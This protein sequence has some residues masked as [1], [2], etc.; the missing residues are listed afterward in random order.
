MAGG[1]P[2]NTIGRATTL[3]AFCTRPATVCRLRAAGRLACCLL[4]TLATGCGSGKPTEAVVKA[5]SLLPLGKPQEAIDALTDDKSAE[6]HYLKYVAL[7]RLELADAAQAE[8]EKAVQ[9]DPGNEKYK[10][11][12]LTSK[13]QAGDKAAAEEIL[14]LQKEHPS[15]ASVALAAMTAYARTGDLAG[16]MTAFKTSV[17]LCDQVPEMLPQMLGVALRSQMGP[18]AQTVMAKL[19]KLAPDYPTLAAQRI[20]VMLITNRVDEALRLARE[21]YEKDKTS[22]SAALI[23]ARAISATPATPEYDKTMEEIARQYPRNPNL[24]QMHSTYLAKS[25]RLPQAVEFLNKAI[26]QVPPDLRD[27]ITHMSIVLPLEMK[28]A[29]LASAQIDRHRAAIRDPLYLGYYEGRLLQVR[30]DYAG[31][32]AAYK[33]VVEAAKD[34]PQTKAMIAREALVWMRQ[35]QLEQGRSQAIQKAADR[36]SVLELEEDTPS[37]AETPADQPAGK[38]APA[39]ASDN[40]AGSSSKT[41]SG[42]TAKAAEKDASTSGGKQPASASKA[43]ADSTKPPAAPRGKFGAGKQT[44]GPVPDATPE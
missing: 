40:G 8:L 32:M 35:I 34:D 36:M 42:K 30:K 12:Q 24:L 16:A 23:F 14:K 21:H 20:A 33:R 19:E 5:R 22:E 44:I 11:I 29:P 39:A 2:R 13:L 15:S 10:V 43:K 28:N 37:T 3:Q 9:Q 41:A 6:G 7:T 27:M 4:L 31:A 17:A 25:G 38:P 1:D 18:E 26:A